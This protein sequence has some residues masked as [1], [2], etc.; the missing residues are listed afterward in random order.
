[1]NLI[2]HIQEPNRLY[3]IWMPSDPERRRRYVVGEVARNEEGEVELQYRVDSQEF[4]KACKKGFKGYPA[5]KTGIATHSHSVLET[6]L[7]RTPPRSRTDFS[8]YLRNFRLEPDANISDFALLGY[9]EAKLPG[10]GFSIL[11]PFEDAIPP[12][13]FM[14]EVAGFRHNSKLEDIQV[15]EEVYFAPEPDN[16]QDSNAVQIISECG[17]IGYINRIHAP[18]FLEWLQKYRVTGVIERVNGTSE[19]PLVYMFIRVAEKPA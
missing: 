11:N 19:R 12:F 16:E 2:E 18:R 8:K 10:D 1:M 6:L 7:R 15:G 5:F 9:S 13:E 17:R 4:E 14:S 3:L